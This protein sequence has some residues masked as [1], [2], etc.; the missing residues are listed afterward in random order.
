VECTQRSLSLVVDTEAGGPLNDIVRGSCFVGVRFEV[1]PRSFVPTI[2][3][4]AM[5][6]AL[7][8]GG[9]HARRVCGASS[10]RCSKAST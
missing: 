3:L 9:L 8:H 2:A 10:S 6:Q 7:G 4:L 1:R 5:P